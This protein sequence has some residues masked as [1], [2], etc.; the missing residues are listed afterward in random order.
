MSTMRT[1]AVIWLNAKFFYC[2][3]QE[4][5]VES[6]ITKWKGNIVLPKGD[7]SRIKKTFSGNAYWSLHLG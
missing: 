2:F 6:F 1:F 7:K 4:R 3:F 5:L